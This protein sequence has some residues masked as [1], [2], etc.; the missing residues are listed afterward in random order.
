MRSKFSFSIFILLISV[1]CM[2]LSAGVMADKTIIDMDDRTEIIPDSIQ[3]VI[4]GGYS[5]APCIMAA[6]GVGDK[7]VGSGGA[8]TTL[9]NET[10]ATIVLPNLKNL[11]DLGRGNTINL[12]SMASLEP[13]LL[14][15]EEDCG[16]QGDSYDKN[17]ELKEKL[18]LFSGKLPY[19][20]IKNAACTDKPSPEAIYSQIE[21][22]GEIFDKQSRSNEVINF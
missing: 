13:D 10:T 15:Y 9:S 5:S 17:K 18:S 4:T 20:I 1:L 6:L 22:L 8:L 12:E 3:K 14:I 2:I 19:V 7:I 21:I 16:G 11:P